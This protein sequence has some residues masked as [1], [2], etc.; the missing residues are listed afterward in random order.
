MPSYYD[1]GSEYDEEE[2]YESEED[3]ISEAQRPPKVGG[4]TDN[5]GEV[6]APISKQESPTKS[7]KPKQA[8]HKKD[9]DP[10]TDKMLDINSNEDYLM[11]SLQNFKPPVDKSLDRSISVF[12]DKKEAPSH[13]PHRVIAGVK[14]KNMVE[15]HVDDINEIKQL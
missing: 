4:W 3:E 14:M 11:E 2:E 7:K 12:G 15:D 5:E 13:D 10:R 9:F 1:D 6:K 8:K